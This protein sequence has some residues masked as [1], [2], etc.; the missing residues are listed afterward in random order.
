MKRKRILKISLFIILIIL[1]VFL[2]TLIGNGLSQFEIIIYTIGIINTALLV[3]L[4]Y[5]ISEEMGYK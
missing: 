2:Y 4:G 3:S 1:E 5:N